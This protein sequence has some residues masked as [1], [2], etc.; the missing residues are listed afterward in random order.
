MK[1]IS[2]ALL[3][4]FIVG[5]SKS[6]KLTD[7]EQKYVTL[8]I[9]L[10]KARQ[11]SSDSVTLRYKLDSVFRA[12]H[13]DTSSYRKTTEAFANIPDRSEKVFRAITDSLHSR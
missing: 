2:V 8:S 10:L 5:C 9:S 4:V 11:A 13:S 12:Y 7:D 3:L 6:E 1:I